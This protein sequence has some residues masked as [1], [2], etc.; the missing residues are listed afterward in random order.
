M[1]RITP[2]GGGP[3]SIKGTLP[4]GWASVSMDAVG[5]WMTGGTPSRRVTE[6]FGGKIPW[7]KSGDL[8]DGYVETTEETISAAGLANSAAKVLP[9][10]T[11]SVALYGATIGRLGLL[12][13]TAA[14]NQACANCVVNPEVATNKF[15]FYYLRQ[16]RQALIEA[17]QGGA[18]PNLTNQIVRNWPLPLPPLHEQERI[19][20]R[21]D[22]LFTYI[23]SAREHLSRVLPILK[24]FRQAVLAAACSGRL[25]E[26]WR[27]KH[28]ETEPAE[29]ALARCQEEKLRDPTGRRVRRRGTAGMPDV[30]TVDLPA[31][32]TVRTIK[33]LVEAGAIVDFQDG[34]H[35]DLYPRKTD[36]GD[37]GVTFLTAT[38]VLNNRVLMSEAPLLRREKASQLRIGF[39]KPR[40][41]LLTHNATVGRV[42]VMPD[43]PGEVILGTSVTYYRLQT[44]YIDPFF[45]CIAM[46]GDFWQAQLRSVMEQ[47]TRNQVS[48]T[49]QVEFSL[50]I[51]PLN[52]QH[53]IVRRVKTLLNL[54]EQIEARSSIAEEKAVRLA[55]SILAKAF[56]GELVLTEAELARREGREYEPA[57]VLLERIKKQRESKSSSKPERKQTRTKVGSASAKG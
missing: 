32:W 44:N 7:V 33:E 20:A 23:K 14:T 52:E 41:V 4:E 35:G 9:P 11:L 53:E 3:T 55:D 45:C 40:D 30:R 25:T 10:G 27:N 13:M 17:G 38:Q 15:L 21:V 42:A 48:I 12:S 19:T 6:Y 8:N 47:T 49:K 24:R 5:T 46:Q 1:V 26:D 57:S 29:Q 43:I 54:A 28:S 16:Q 2:K 31:T 36:F 37:S 39:A 18:Q 50:V 51:P 22:D 56:C 34:N